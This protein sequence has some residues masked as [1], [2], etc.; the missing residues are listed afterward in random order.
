[1]RNTSFKVDV[2][3]DVIRKSIFSEEQITKLNI[4]F[5]QSNENIN[6]KI[7]LFFKT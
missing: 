3:G 1:M 5:N 6:N 7:S 4:F 2:F